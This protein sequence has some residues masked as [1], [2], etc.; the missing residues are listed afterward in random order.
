M[1]VC[2]HSTE[3]LARFPALS[4]LS[5]ELLFVIE[6]TSYIFPSI[7]GIINMQVEDNGEF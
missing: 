5:F 1:A 3:W 7:Q 4:G 2:R 6:N